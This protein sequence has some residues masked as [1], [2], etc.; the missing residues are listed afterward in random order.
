MTYG[1][2]EAADTY[3]QVKWCAAMAV[4]EAKTWAWEEF[5]EAMGNHFWMALKRFWTTIRH[6]RMG[7]QC[8]VYSEDG[9][10]LT[11][12]KDVVDR[13]REY[14]EDILNPREEAGPRDSGTGSLISSP[15][16]AEVVK[17]LFAGR[18]PGEIR[19]EFL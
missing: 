11:S 18:S 15:E 9:A 16:V 4:V 7:K 6:L 1:T 5:G 8:I 19:P 12:T 13:W 14:F 17:K 3:R 10:L 2:P